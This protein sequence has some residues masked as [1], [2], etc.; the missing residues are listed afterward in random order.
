MNNLLGD[1]Y[2]LFN[3]F[4]SSQ[5]DLYLWGYDCSSQSFLGTNIYNIVG[6]IAIVSMSLACILYYFIINAAS[7]NKGWKW[8]VYGLV[9]EVI[10][11][12]IA[13]GIT[14]TA[15]NNG[16]ICQDLVYSS[17]GTQTITGIDC[18]GFGGAN[19]I[20]SFILFVVFSF[21]LKRFSSN[22]THTPWKSKF[23]TRNN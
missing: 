5:L 3:A 6:L 9:W 14:L 8:C 18:W 7:L 11:V 15:L 19:F 17:D 21:I 20:V 23:L 1:F 13:S 12:L 22:C 16:D 2:S 10:N 4:Y